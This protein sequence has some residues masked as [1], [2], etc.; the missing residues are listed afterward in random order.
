MLRSTDEGAKRIKS[1]SLQIKSRVLKTCSSRK[2][3]IR[4]L[5]PCRLTGVVRLTTSLG[6]APYTHRP[7]DL[8]T[9]TKKTSR[10]AYVFRIGNLVT[11]VAE[12]SFDVVG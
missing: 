8:D 9:E 4:M 7:T 12:T 2:C 5:L 1:Q 3:A 6:K 11:F 10:T